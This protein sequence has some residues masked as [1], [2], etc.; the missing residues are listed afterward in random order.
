MDNRRDEMTKYLMSQEPRVIVTESYNNMPMVFLKKKKS[1]ENFEEL[2][3]VSLT[4]KS[5][6]FASANGNGSGNGD[7]MS[8][9]LK[10]QTPMIVRNSSVIENF[11]G[12]N[13]VSS[14]E[15]IIPPLNTDIRFSEELP[16][17]TLKNEVSQ[18]HPYFSIEDSTLCALPLGS[19]LSPFFYQGSDLRNIA[20]DTKG[21]TPREIEYDHRHKTH[22]AGLH[23][24]DEIQENFSWAIP[25]T[26][27]I[28]LDLIKK[29]LIHEVTA[30]HAC[31]SC[32]A[33]CI[34]ETM[35]D[36]F[37]VSGAVGWAPDISST[38]IMASVPVDNSMCG[39]GKPAG[40]VPYLEKNGVADNSCIDYSWCSGD[41]K[42]CKSVSSQQHF[43][44]NLT[45]TLNAQ[46]PKN[47]YGCYFNNI[48]KWLYKLDPGSD[49]FG[50]NQNTPIDKFR[51]TVRSHILDYGPVIGGF[52]VLKNF[53]QPFH[54]TNGG[55]Y[56]D[57]ADYKNSTGG[58][59][60]F[61]DY[62]TSETSGLHAVSIVG[63][64][65]AKNIQYDSNKFGDV[66]YWHCRNSWG[67]N[68]GDKGFFK[69]AMYPFNKIA[70]FDKEVMTDIGGPIG[71]MILIRATKSP[72]IADLNQISQK[73]LN[74]IKRTKPDVYYKAD[75][76]EVRLI[77]RAN[78]LDIDIENENKKKIEDLD[79]DFKKETI[80]N[81]NYNKLWWFI[82]LA[83]IV[84]LI[85]GIYILR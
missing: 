29:S 74:S 5:S 69:I 20:N 53:F 66:P 71:S 39:G 78:L 7:R 24:H 10:S 28:P 14:S 6:F 49:V 45:S 42:V 37:V 70:Q 3:F 23:I 54:K 80:L 56:F 57:R 50:I 83:A 68:W 81:K 40:V 38:F 4:G 22:P 55:V 44:S 12:S 32:W 59:I 48:K 82:V 51:N 47:P 65:V 52:V 31:G 72:E 16:Q 67:T 8:N 85:A 36:C 17:H 64:G 61:N 1:K 43:G 76:E 21:Y 25:T 33:V 34:A 13:S 58:V 11:T 9:Y 27:D 73:Y 15:I 18:T 35:S 26:S 75:P 41:D 60:K 62:M 46:I 30:Q 77:N 2:P 19:K 84:F 63:F 79:N